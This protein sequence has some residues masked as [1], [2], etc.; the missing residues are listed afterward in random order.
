MRKRTL[1]PL[2]FALTTI[3]CAGTMHA[4][5]PVAVHKLEYHL[6]VKAPK[7][8]IGN[9]DPSEYTFTIVA[10]SWG[11]QPVGGFS[12]VTPAYCILRAELLVCMISVHEDE[13]KFELKAQHIQRDPRSYSATE[14]AE[15]DR[16][17]K[18]DE[19]FRDAHFRKTFPEPFC[20]KVHLGITIDQFGFSGGV[21]TAAKWF[22][23][24]AQKDG[25][26]QYYITPEMLAATRKAHVPNQSDFLTD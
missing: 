25:R 21:P 1:L 17:W 23:V 6:I 19:G 4:K 8:I 14:R 13:A 10:K 20:D 22:D 12:E 9:L 5:A 3:G 2:L 7:T 11:K 18:T 26:C 16:L 24:E 15:L